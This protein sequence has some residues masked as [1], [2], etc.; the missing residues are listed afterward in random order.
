MHNDSNN[1]MQDSRLHRNKS[2]GVLLSGVLPEW[3]RES[4]GSE[5]KF[6]CSTRRMRQFPITP[7]ALELSIYSFKQTYRE[8][9]F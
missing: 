5:G 9:A 1:S 8:E 7:N 2:S 3:L 6:T 4:D